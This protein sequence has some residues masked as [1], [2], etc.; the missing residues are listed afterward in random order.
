MFC[1]QCGK[2]LPDDAM[3]CPECG[4]KQ[5]AAAAPVVPAAPVAEA[6]AAAPVAPT[7]AAP[8]NAAVPAQ[9]PAKKK[10]ASKKIIG[11]VTA[12]VVVVAVLL[13]VLLAGGKGGSAYDSISKDMIFANYMGDGVYYFFNV[14]GEG[15]EVEDVDRTY[16]NADGSR[17]F[18]RT[19]DYELYYMDSKFK[20]V[21]IADDVYN[22]TISYTGE[23]IA[24][25]TFEDSYDSYD[26]TLY[27]YNVKGDKSTKIDSG[28]YAY[29]VCISPSGKTVGYLKDYESYDD[30]TLY[31]GGV[32]IDSKKVDK[33][34]C[35]PVAV[36]D[37][38]KNFYYAN[39]S[40]KL[41]FYNGKESEKIATDVDDELWF[42][43]S[44]SEVVFTKNGKT[45][46]YTPKMSEPTKILND[47][48]YDFITPEALVNDACSEY[49]TIIGKASLKDSVLEAYDG[50]F[51]LNNKGTDT[52]KISN[53]YRYQLSGDG[54]SILYISGGDLYKVSKF[55]E[56]MTEKLLYT[57]DYLERVIASKDLSKIYL[58]TDEDE[59]YYYKSA[60]KIEKISNDFDAYSAAAYNESAG[61]IFYV[62]DEDLYSAGTN[63][64]SKKKVMED[65]YGVQSFLNGVIYFY[66]GED[67]ET[68][69]YMEKK[70]VEMYT[71]D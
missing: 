22:A 32:N 18:Y 58:V 66:E 70:A 30:N 51:W 63:A 10:G 37:N 33:D 34:G 44:I 71:E 61:R 12:A 20:S 59:L 39:S 52:V 23:Y 7:P 57:G 43:K 54:K 68:A 3:F 41:Y 62:E 15:T 53:A 55:N 11:I 16:Y 38:G 2:E 64:K 17:I 28:V 19:D 35:Y 9:V 48:I 8:V 4:A 50:L 45:Y 25:T 40:E 60:K 47:D 27:I 36:S 29:E 31:I 21:K 56:R 46:F 24:Y 65:V 5:E 69:Y 49:G 42:N 1:N 67:S 6:P 26:T 13:V 14:K